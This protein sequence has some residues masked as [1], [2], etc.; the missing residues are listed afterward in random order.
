MADRPS[1]EPTAISMVP[2]VRDPQYREIYSNASF[3]GISPFDVTL[4]FSKSS[5]IAGQQV[6]VDQVSVTMSP[7]HFKGF[8]KSLTETLKAYESV[9]GAINTPDAD[10]SPLRD[11]AQLEQ[12]IREARDKNREGRGPTSSTEKKP[13][14]KRSRAAARE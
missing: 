14:A 11:A 7:Q 8:C 12:I 6:H 5:D 3:S 1:P 13:P 4:T 10:L 2:R 9:F